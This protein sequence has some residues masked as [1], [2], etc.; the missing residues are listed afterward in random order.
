M[1][2]APPRGWPSDAP[3]RYLDG[4]SPAEIAWEWLRRDPDYRSLTPAF[5]DQMDGDLRIALAAS[6]AVRE[7]WGCLNAP[8]PGAT[9]AERPVLW[10]SSID[11]AVLAVMAVPGNDGHESAFDLQRWRAMATLVMSPHAE[12]LLLRDAGSSVRLDVIS[13]TLRNGPVMLFLDLAR[14]G[15]MEPRMAALRRFQYLCRT[16]QF[17][18]VNGP[19]TQQSRRIILALRAHDAIMQGASIRD[20]GIM[21]HGDERVRVEWPGSG[22]ALKSQARRLIGLAREMAA[23]GYRRLL[24]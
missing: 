9:W 5:I 13:G 4:A 20:I 7:R 10:S 22:D 1:P 14:F 24:G 6:A 16:G 8:S 11:P 3:Y 2:S 21:V 15:L 12:H 19:P 18:P 17:P 23:G